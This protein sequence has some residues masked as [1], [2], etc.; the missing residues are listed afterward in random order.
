MLILI[1]ILKP[2]DVTDEEMQALKSLESYL[3]TVARSNSGRV[4]KGNFEDF[5]KDICSVSNFDFY[6]RIQYLKR[7]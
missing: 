3:Y 7:T 1:S 4:S 5:C 2:A 6:V